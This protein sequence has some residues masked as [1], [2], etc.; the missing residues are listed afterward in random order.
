MKNTKKQ[1]RMFSYFDYDGMADH[2]EK[3]AAEGWML[4]K[5]TNRSFHYV[6][7]QPQKVKFAVIYYANRS[8]FDPVI[9]EGQQDL[10]QFCR[11]AGWHFVDSLRQIHVY[12]NYNENPLSI[13][14]EPT[15]HVANVHKAMKKNFLPGNIAVA[16]LSFLLIFSYG[17]GFFTNPLRSFTDASSFFIIAVYIILLALVVRELIVYYKWRKKAKARAADGVMVPSGKSN[18]KF[19]LIS[20]VAVI[21]VIIP[22]FSMQ[23]KVMKPRFF[24]AVYAGIGG[25]TLTTYIV[26]ELLKKLKVPRNTNR[27]ITF[28]LPFILHFTLIAVIAAA[29]IRGNIDIFVKKYEPVETYEY[30]GRQHEIYHMDI[31]LKIEDILPKSEINY[32]DYSYETES[33][34]GIFA[35][36]HKITQFA[37]WGE[38]GDAAVPELRYEIVQAKSKWVYDILFDYIFDDIDTPYKSDIPDEMQPKLIP[39][40]EKLWN[41]DKVWRL[42]LDGR[43]TGQ[44]LLCIEDKIIDIT[45]YFESENINKYGVGEKLKNFG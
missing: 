5:I 25:V 23:F 33:K 28:V 37:K 29:I 20:L 7:A 11:R 35:S 3:M 13:E 16:I 14:T 12:C 8:D 42:E 31:P 15:I 17:M 4:E 19:Q 10:N 1:T 45:F 36:S 26:K 18:I 27:I 38:R 21:A 9:T 2:F 40:E 41:A 30:M 39:Q 34:E 24:I 6:K 32:N 22:Y 44:Y 43:Q